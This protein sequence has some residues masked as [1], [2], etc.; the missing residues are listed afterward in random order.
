MYDV[1]SNL[2]LCTSY[3][4]DES[5][6]K[7][8]CHVPLIQ[9]LKGPSEKINEYLRL[10]VIMDFNDDELKKKMG[11]SL[12]HNKHTSTTTLSL[13]KMWTK[14]VFHFASFFTFLYVDVNRCLPNM[15]HPLK[16]Q[17]LIPTKFFF[18]PSSNKGKEIQQNTKRSK[19]GKGILNLKS[20]EVIAYLKR[21][22]QIRSWKNSCI[23]GHA[24]SER[25][26]VFVL[27]ILTC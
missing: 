20:R 13:W 9:A 7:I 26:R 21:N 4:I 11:P 22:T 12:K 25:V 8:H 10:W 6:S 19:N 24:N 18:K 2:Y 23:F 3:W 27:I 5:I 1:E 17:Y 15:W 14:M 16:I